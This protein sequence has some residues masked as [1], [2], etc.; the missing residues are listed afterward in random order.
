[1]KKHFE[2]VGRQTGIRTFARFGSFHPHWV[3]IWL[4]A[5]AV[6]VFLHLPLL[7]L[8]YFWDE[9]GYYIPAAMDFFHSG[10]LIPSSTLPNGHTPLVIVYLAMA[11]RAFGFSPL[12]TRTAMIAVAAATLAGLY[13][14]GRRVANREIRCWSVLLLALSPLFFA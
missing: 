13:A 12:V 3:F 14:L 11:W 8:P 7:R 2:K 4:A 9:A 5:S 6:L 1:M 10:R